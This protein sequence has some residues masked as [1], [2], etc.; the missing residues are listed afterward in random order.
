MPALEAATYRC[1]VA[2]DMMHA[3]RRVPLVVGRTL[4]D[5]AD[6]LAMVVPASCRRSGRCREC[7]VEVRSGGEALSVPAPAEAYLRPGFRLACCARIE[8]EPPDDLEF[9]VLRRRLR[10]FPPPP[11]PALEIDPVVTA[12]GGRVLYDGADVDAAPQ[13]ILGIA[14]DVGTTTVVLELVDLVSGEAL[15]AASFENPQRFG[16][17]ERLAG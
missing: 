2:P 1:G 17:S 6:E 13:R 4:F 5:A 9:A 11:G 16:G 7:V 12:E 10:I 14:L 8:R 15:A 3:G